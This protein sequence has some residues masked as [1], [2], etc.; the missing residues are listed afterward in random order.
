MLCYVSEMPMVSKVNNERRRLEATAIVMLGVIGAEFGKE[1]EP[2]KTKGDEQKRGSVEGFGISD[3]SLAWH[4]S[5]LIC[6]YSEMTAA[7]W[8]TLIHR[9]FITFIP[10]AGYIIITTIHC[11]FRQST[12]LP[13]IESA[14]M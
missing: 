12:C 14:A 4:T 5:K 7:N 13:V 11:V 1:I 8:L 6:G 10:N 9:R 3:H 2:K